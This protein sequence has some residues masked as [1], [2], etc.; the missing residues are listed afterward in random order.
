MCKGQ[1]LIHKKI[2]QT[3]KFELKNAIITFTMFNVR[4]SVD[5][6]NSYFGHSIARGDPFRFCGR[7]KNNRPGGAGTLVFFV[8][9]GMQKILLSARGRCAGGIVSS[10]VENGPIG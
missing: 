6:A 10:L 5:A 4:G 1:K 9:P 8:T 2:K 3:I 7:N